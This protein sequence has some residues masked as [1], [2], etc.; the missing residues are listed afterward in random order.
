MEPKAES[1]A[2][3]DGAVR[4]LRAKGPIAAQLEDCTQLLHRLSASLEACLPVSEKLYTS[5]D[6]SLMK[7]IL[8]GNEVGANSRALDH[9]L[10]RSRQLNE[11]TLENLSDLYIAVEKGQS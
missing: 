9:A 1:K 4:L 6:D 7:L 11:T 5:A 2:A 10:R 3:R 8:W